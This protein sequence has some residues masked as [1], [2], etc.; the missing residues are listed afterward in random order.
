MNISPPRFCPVAQLLAAGEYAKHGWKTVDQDIRTFRA[1]VDRNAEEKIEEAYLLVVGQVTA[2]EIAEKMNVS[3][4]CARRRLNALV[5]RGRLM[6][7]KRHVEG[8]AISAKEFVFFRGVA[9]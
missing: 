7:A 2:N 3:D 9:K 8:K 5:K 1:T 4:S 6:K